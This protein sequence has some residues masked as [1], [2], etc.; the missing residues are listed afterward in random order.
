MFFEVPK[1]LQVLKII[2]T[3]DLLDYTKGSTL[4]KVF[5]NI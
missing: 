2:H 4:L 5:G 3:D 1:Q